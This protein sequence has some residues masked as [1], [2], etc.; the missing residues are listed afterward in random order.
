MYLICVLLSLTPLRSYGSDEQ[1]ST[2]TMIVTSQVHVPII[3]ILLN[4]CLQPEHLVI[5]SRLN[6]SP[7]LVIH[8]IL[9]R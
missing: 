8:H 6:C 3:K 4:K 1:S 2:E 5:D 9:G 7:L